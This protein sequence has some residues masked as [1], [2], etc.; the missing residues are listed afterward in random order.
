MRIAAWYH[1]NE[2]WWPLFASGSGGYIF[3]EASSPRAFK[4]QARL[5]GPKMQGVKCLS[6]YYH[7]YGSSMGCITVYVRNV[8]TGDE[9]V[10]W[11]KSG[12]RG[13][14]WW[15]GFVTVRQQGK[16]QV[17]EEYRR[18]RISLVSRYLTIIPRERMGH[19]PTQPHGPS[20]LMGWDCERNDIALS[21]V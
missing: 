9:R 4:D 8:S 14:S 5:V 3:M 21:L 12:D 15:E 13:N 11:L 19:K 18:S 1:R 17:S 16:Y 10:L 7:M 2:Y 6:F 20:S